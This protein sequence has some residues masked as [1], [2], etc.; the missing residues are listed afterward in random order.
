[1]RNGRAISS[2]PPKNV[3]VEVKEDVME[4]ET[5]IVE[6]AIVT[7]NE[8]EIPTIK[9]TIETTIEDAIQDEIDNLTKEVLVSEATK[10]SKITK[11][12]KSTRG[13]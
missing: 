5:P 10:V 11:Q 1:M 2:T 8:V 9:T 7:T 6:E 13:N 12:K 3:V 4:V